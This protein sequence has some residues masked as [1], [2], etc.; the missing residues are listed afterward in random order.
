MTREDWLKILNTVPDGC[1]I[2]VE[3]F[4]GGDVYVV[5]ARSVEGYRYQYAGNG[6]W[7]A[8]GAQAA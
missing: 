6:N 3:Y 5:F 1:V 4:H 8:S 2:E 7:V